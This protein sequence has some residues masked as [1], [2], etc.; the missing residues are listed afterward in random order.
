VNETRTAAPHSLVFAVNMLVL[1]SD[2]DTFSFKEI[3]NWLSEAG[4]CNARLLDSP[5]VSPLILATKA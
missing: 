4:F 5:G 2:G 1:S 3:S